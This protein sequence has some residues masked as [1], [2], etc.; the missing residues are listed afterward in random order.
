[1]SVQFNL[2][3]DIKLEFNRNQHIK[4]VVYG[5]AT[6]AT[7]IALVIF[8]FSFLTVD[9]LQKKLLSDAQG[10]I[11]K[12]SNQLKQINDLDKIL[13][14]Q[15][16]LNALPG[17]HQQ[18]H[19]ASRLFGYLPQLTPS[20]LNIGKLNLD[21]GASTIEIDGTTDTVETINKFV[22]TLKFTSYTASTAQNTQKPAF[23]NVVLTKVDRNDKVSSYTVNASFDPNLFTANKAVQLIV[24]NEI[25]TRSVINTPIFNGQTD[26]KNQQG[27]GQ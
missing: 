27:S 26:T 12:Y 21:T 7:G 6:L 19:Y 18:K 3:P 11:N 23:S 10:D 15:N 25:T 2:L 14:I 20:N 16:Q 1:M 9:V 13:T 22:D 5:I 24:P 4:R 17:L 8:V